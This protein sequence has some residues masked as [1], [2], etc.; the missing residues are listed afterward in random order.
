MPLPFQKGGWA[1]PMKQE[2][3]LSFP[4]GA[5]FSREQPAKRSWQGGS[6]GG[7]RRQPSLSGTAGPAPNSPG[8]HSLPASPLR[9]QLQ[10]RH[11]GLFNSQI[12]GLVKA[13]RLRK[14]ELP[15][16][17]GGGARRGGAGNATFSCGG[18]SHYKKPAFSSS[19]PNKVCDQ[20]SYT[21]GLVSAQRSQAG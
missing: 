2:G 7:G 20:K 14:A 19:S 12:R 9:S 1:D 13:S 10:K 17:R 15:W 8:S 18:S 11:A 16:E 4:A 5:A 3:N 21:K 6:A